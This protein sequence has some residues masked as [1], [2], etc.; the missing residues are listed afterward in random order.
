MALFLVSLVRIESSGGHRALKEAI[1]AI[2]TMAREW[3]IS[4]AT[5]SGRS[6]KTG[7]WDYTLTPAG[8][9]EVW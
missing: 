8:A 6:C 1:V 9:Q 2:T 5:R 4:S 7:S 3:G